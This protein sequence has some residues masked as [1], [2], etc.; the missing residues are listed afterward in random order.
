MFVTLADMLCRPTA[1]RRKE[2]P[3]PPRAWPGTTTAEWSDLAADDGDEVALEAMPLSV[4]ASSEENRGT[5]KSTN[6]QLVINQDKLCPY[7][8]LFSFFSF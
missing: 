6:Q 2:S 8:A 1:C 5:V 7:A 4:T 3:D